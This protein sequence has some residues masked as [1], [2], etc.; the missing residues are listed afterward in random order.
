MNKFF[1]NFV[2]W[3]HN[4]WCKRLFTLQFLC[5]L[6]SIYE[7]FNREDKTNDSMADA[8][9]FLVFFFFLFSQMKYKIHV[10]HL[11]SLNEWILQNWRKKNYYFFLFN[12]ICFIFYWMS[13][14]T[15][16]LNQQKKKIM[17]VLQL[18]NGEYDSLNRK[19]PSSIRVESRLWL[20]IFGD[21]DFRTFFSIIF[22]HLNRSTYTW[23]C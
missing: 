1:L 11:F 21:F 20:F 2:S 19:A 17:Y 22:S 23:Y 5:T 4:F 6:V 14:Y 3:F 12:F 13:V 18:M 10:F 7:T 15:F 16:R 9:F 8:V